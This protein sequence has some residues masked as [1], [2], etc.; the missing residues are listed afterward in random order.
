M[1]DAAVASIVS[2]VVTVATML[3]GLFT[4]WIKVAY[5]VTKVEETSSKLDSNTHITNQ[6]KD[7]ATKAYEHAET[8]DADR[9]RIMEMLSDHDGRIGNLEAQM[10]VVKTAVD[11]VSKELASTR[12]EIRGHLQTI[13]NKL[14]I[15]Q[16]SAT[17]SMGRAVVA[18]N[19]QGA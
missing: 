1:S 17:A 14:D 4:L 5:G 9:S 8:C 18:D 3:A 16:M 13:T 15:I 6:A 11:T 19:K 12:H 10:T 7:A 2:A